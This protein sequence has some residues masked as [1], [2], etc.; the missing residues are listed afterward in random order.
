MTKYM[1]YAA[2]GVDYS[3][4][5]PFK[6]Q[7]QEAAQETAHYL[8]EFDLTEVT[9]SRGESV[10]LIE[11]P[12]CYL[13]H[14]EEGLGTKNLV[15]DAMYKLTGRSYYDYVARD[16]IAMIVNDMI[17]LGAL[18]ISLAMHLAAG[19]GDWFKDEQRVRDLIR[20]WKEG[21]DLARCT[22]AGGE[23]PTLKDMIAPETVVL[24][25]SAVGMIKPKEK[26]IRPRIQDGDAI[27]LLASSGIHANGLTMARRIADKLPD[28]YMTPLSDGQTYGEALVQPTAIYVPVIEACLSHNV[29]L[30]YTVN[31]TGHGW[32]KLMRAV[33]PF[34]YII[35]NPGE[36]QALFPFIQEHG[37]VSDEEAYG[38]FNMGAGFA[39]YVPPEQVHKVIELAAC[40]DIKSWQGGHVEKRDNEKKVI[41]SP[42]GLEYAAE[43]LAVR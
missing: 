5:D 33:E 18:P 15:A 25:G 43:S 12:D 17:T 36:P 19:H 34:M 31:I 27:V 40:H 26:L 35:N 29:E 14:V 16:T 20:G 8:R 6:R 32:R 21:C 38:N 23:T 24:S 22:W 37:P 4:M 7:A 28:G 39:L 13:A 41:I 11:A 30:H 42:K 9:W 10:Y 2:T 3:L 1:T